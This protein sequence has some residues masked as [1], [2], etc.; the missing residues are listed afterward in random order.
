MI[1]AR[2]HQCFCPFVPAG[3]FCEGMAL[4]DKAGLS[5]SDLLDVLGLGAIANPMFSLKGPALQERQYPPAFPL[6]H[7]QKDMRLALALG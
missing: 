2:L 7:Q 4:A 5:Q 6:K 1:N 3:A